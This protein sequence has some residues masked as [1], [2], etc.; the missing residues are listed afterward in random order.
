MQFKKDEAKAERNPK[1]ETRKPNLR[2]ND[3]SGPFFGLRISGFF[4]I[5]AFGFRISTAEQGSI[6]VG[7]RLHIGTYFCTK[8]KGLLSPALFCRGGEGDRFPPPAQGFK[9]PNF[10]GILRT[11]FIRA[12]RFP[13]GLIL[14]SQGIGRT[15]AQA[16]RANVWRSG[17]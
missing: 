16:R 8:P 2:Q 12:R 7:S 10:S 14:W 15:T 13:Q 9:A 6:L 1:A 11:A 4:R 17:N 5:S 3:R